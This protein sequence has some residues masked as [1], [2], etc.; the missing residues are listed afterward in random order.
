MK[1]QKLTLTA[2]GP[3]AART[4]LDFSVFGG[5]GLFLIGGD[6][7]A[8]KTALFDAITFA[9]YGETSGENRKTT[10]LRSDFAAPDAETCVELTF[11]HR[12]RSYTV[13]RWPDQQRAAKR[14]SGMV[15]VP[16]KAE[17]IREPDEP[18]SGASA[19]TDAIVKLLGIDAKQ[20]AQVSMLAQNDF[21]KLLNAP[22]ADRAAI[23][24]RIFDTADHQRLGQAAVEHARKAD[25]E[26][27]RLD[28]VLLMHIGA[29]LGDGAD[30]VTADELREMQAER[31]PFA[32]GAAAELG[33]HLLEAD[34]ANEK[35]QTNVVKELDEKLARGN[36]G[37]K[38]AEER[39]ARRAKLAELI[40]EEQRAADVE[41]QTA[42]ITAD[43]EKRTATVK[44]NI[45][46]NE[47]DRLALSQAEAELLK[48]DH[49]IEL[50]EGLAADCKRLLQDADAADRCRRPPD[51]VRRRAGSTRPRRGRIQHD[52]ASIER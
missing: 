6:T 41:H 30:E 45:T 2:F 47:T 39:A 3:Y 26:C 37:M 32:A 36:A 17:L 1:P 5:N 38:I 40:A 15:K 19:V 27:R 34:E 50:A 22:S 43:L 51:R 21:T 31:D 7:G 28:D 12:G 35:H 49:R 33:L 11:T 4:E 52:A 42:L 18:V 10:M 29:L 16:A 44:T 20:F 25:E 14:G 13:R 9:L 23:L 24:R 8:G 46:R 48:T